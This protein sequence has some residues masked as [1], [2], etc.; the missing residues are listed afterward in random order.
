MAI[1]TTLTLIYAVCVVIM[2]G[3]F[4]LPM[5][6]IKAQEWQIPIAQTYREDGPEDA[7]NLVLAGLIL[8]PIFVASI[9]WKLCA[10]AI[11]RHLR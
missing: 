11:R 3:W 8:A 9:L 6:N 10:I 7:V 2:A 1:L 5:P 4:F